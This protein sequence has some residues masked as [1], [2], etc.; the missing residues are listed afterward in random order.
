MKKLLLKC[1]SGRIVPLTANR[2]NGDLSKL[3]RMLSGVTILID[4]RERDFVRFLLWRASPSVTGSSESD[5][6]VAIGATRL[7]HLSWPWAS[8]IQWS[9]DSTN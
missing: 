1:R 6:A 2:P 3:K 9:G 4:E 8:A 5:N 7:P